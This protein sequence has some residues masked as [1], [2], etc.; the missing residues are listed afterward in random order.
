M[1]RLEPE[2]SPRIP[3][4][5]LYN[6]GS[7]SAAAGTCDKHPFFDASPL[8]DH[9]LPVM[10]HYSPVM[11]HYSVVATHTAVSHLG[12]KETLFVCIVIY[13]RVYVNFGFKYW[14]D[15]K[16]EEESL[17]QA[18]DA[19]ATDV[20]PKDAPEK[21]IQYI[22]RYHGYKKKPQ[23]ESKARKNMIAYLKNTKGFKMA[24]FKGKT[25]D[26]IRPIF[27][28]SQTSDK[29]GLRYNSKVFTQAMFDCDNY[30]SSKSDNDSWS[31]SNLFDSLTKPE[32]DLPTT[33]SALIIE[34]WVSDSEEHS[35][36]IS[37]PPMSVAPLVP[38]RPHSPSKG[39][40]R[41]KKTCFVCKSKTHLIKDCDF[42]ARTLAQRSYASRDIQ[43]NH[44]R[45]LL[46][47]VSAAAPSK[48]KPV[49]SAAAR[50][51]GAVRPKFSKTRPHIAPYAVSK[52]KAPIRRP[53]IRHTSPKPSISPLRVN[54][55]KPSAVS[56]ARVNAANPSAVRVNAAN[57]SAV[58]AA[59]VNA[60]RLSAVSAARINVVKPSAVTAVQHNHTKNVWRP[61]TLVLDHVFRTTSAS[62]TLKRFNYNDAL[63]RSKFSWVFFLATNDETATVL[64][65]FIVGIENLLSLKAKIIRCDNRTEF[66]NADLNQFCGLKGIKREFSIPRT[67]Q[68]N[69]I[70]E[71]KNRTLIEATRTLLADSLLSIPFW[72]EAVNIACYVQNRVLVTK[73]HNK[74]PYELLHGRL[75]SIGFMRPFGCPIT[76][77]NTVDLLGKFQ[78]KV[79]EGFLV[80]YSVCSKAFRVFNSRTR[81]V[82]ETLLVNFMENKLN[83]AGSGPAWLF[84]IDSLSQTMNYHPVLAENQSNPTA[85]FQ[86]TEKAG[87]EGTQ[88]YVLFPV[89]VSP[90]IYSLSCGDQAREQGDKAMNKE[91]VFAAGLEFTNSTNDFTV[92]GPLVSATELKFTNSTNDFPAVGPLN[93]AAELNFTNS[94]NDFSAAGPSNAAMPNLEDFS[95]NADD[96][97]AEANTNNMESIISRFNFSRYIFDSLV[98]NVDSSSKFYMVGKGCSGV[99]SPLF[100]NML[101]VREVDAE[102]EVQVPTHDDVDQE[103]VTEEIADDQV[104][105]KCSVLIHR[106]EGLESANTAQQLEIIKLKARVKKLERINKVVPTAK[107]A[108]VAISAVKPAAKPK[109][110][111]VVPTAPAE[112][113]ESHAQA[114]DAQ[115]TDVQP[116]DVQAK[117]IQYIRRYH[118]YKKKPQSES[119]AR[120][121]MIDYLKNTEEME[122]EQEEII[123]SINETPAQ[124]VAKRRRL[125]E[126]AKE[127]KDL[128]KQ[129]EVVADEDDDV[130]VEATPIGTKVSVVNYEIVMINNKPRY[131]I[132]RADD[133]HQLYT[134]FITLLKNFDREDLEDLW[135]IMKA[136][137]STS[138]AT[139]FTDDYLLATL[140]NMFEKTD[141]HD[142]IWRSQQTEHGQ[143]LVK[144]WK[145][146]TSCGVH[147][148]T[149]TTIMFVLRV[150]KKYP[151]SMFTLEQLVNVARLQVEEESEMSLELLR[152]T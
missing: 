132:F 4:K 138:K 61:K 47:T 135:K 124:K 92:A 80:G 75:P 2:T 67:P 114:K 48:S 142:V 111:K 52:S 32:Q 145:L 83:V 27:Q 100:E 23:S 50:I 51:V 117:G 116:K 63:G 57:P 121:N 73:P 10:D 129:L 97:G 127:A 84:D 139:N 70:A 125:R 9:Y 5:D 105:D 74:T 76:I 29:A 39:L 71:R 140:K 43:M 15:H 69:G 44:F 38:L 89:S 118:G 122:K 146:L 81:I 147:I 58:S 60:A 94:T 6:D 150:E 130:F 66:K 148:I 20:Q 120:K 78:G 136:R 40:K 88:T 17:T 68:Q 141:A 143:A 56:A 11:D 110:L 45:I 64:K 35:G 93:S 59:R 46:Y 25:Y 107:P 102:E 55:A 53:F 22:R 42:H 95:H 14:C 82:Q 72:A 54:A 149:F 144:S 96:V 119:E 133:T 49:L 128:K 98:R 112:E 104:L 101:Q 109:V 3:P 65:T 41:P 28:A 30:Y 151:L 34:D 113:E 16:E 33:S 86:D 106:V 108:V 21:G 26:Q 90:D 103:N 79:D 12:E 85:G 152:F 99:E 24:F 115:A 31:P 8:M 87:E 18:K 19:Q 37:P 7:T 137:F 91:K 126:Q 123:K 134:S 36:L 13:L 62:M 131:K 77:L 1:V